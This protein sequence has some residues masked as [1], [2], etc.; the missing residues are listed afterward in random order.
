M[1]ADDDPP[2]EITTAADITNKTKKLYLIQSFSND[3]FYIRND[4]RNGSKKNLNTSNIVT[5]N[6]EFYFLDADIIDGTQYYYIV[7][8]GTGKYIHVASAVSGQALIY[9]NAPAANDTKDLYRFKIVKNNTRN[10]Y[11]IIAKNSDFSLLKKDGNWST[12]VIEL[13][14]ADDDKSCWN[15]V[16]KTNFSKP[17]AP[18]S[19]SSLN[20]AKHNYYIQNNNYTTF[21]LIPGTQ[22]VTTNTQTDDNKVNMMWYFVKAPA[23]ENDPYMDYYYI[24]HAQTGK[25]LRYTKNNTENSDQAVELSNYISSEDDRFK[26]IIVRGSVLDETSTTYC[27]APYL[28]RVQRTENTIS[29]CKKNNGDGGGSAFSVAGVFKE[30]NGNNFTHWNFISATLATPTISVDVTA[31]TFSISATDFPTGCEIRYTT[32][33]GTQDAPTATT[34]SVYTTPVTIDGFTNVKAAIVGYGMVLSEIADV[35]VKCATPTLDYDP[36]THTV[37]LACA[38][39]GSIIH[40]K[41]GDGD[42]TEYNG[43]FNNVVN[44]N[45]I[46]AYA[47][48]A[49][50]LDS[51]PMVPYTVLD[52]CATPSIVVNYNDGTATVTIINNED[53][54]TVHYT[55][56]GSVPNGDS[57]S[58]PLTFDVTSNMITSGMTVR[59]IAVKEHY[60]NSNMAEETVSQVAMPVI[61]IENNTIKITCATD[62]AAIYYTVGGGAATAYTDA[63]GFE[64]SGKAITAYATKTGMVT[65]ATAEADASTTKLQLTAPVITYNPATN[66]VVITSISGATIKYSTGQTETAAGEPTT[67]YNNGDTGFDLPNYHHVIK[68][69]AEMSTAESSEVAILTIVIQ[70][71]T[72][73]SNPRPYLIQSV[74]CTDFYMIPGDKANNIF[75]LNTS[76]LGSA[77]MEWCF[78][79]AGNE[80]GVDYYFIKNNNF[81]SNPYLRYAD[82]R[83]SMQTTAT[84]NAA[85]E[86]GKKAYWFSIVYANT[87]SNPG[88]YIHPYNNATVGN[89]LCK[90]KGNNVTNVVNLADATNTANSN[91]R[92]NFIPSTSYSVPL[93]FTAWGEG[94]DYKYYKIKKEATS[95]VSTHYLLPRT[96]TV[97]YA[98]AS[99]A[100]NVSGSENSISWYFDKDDASSDKWVSYYYVVNAATGE[101]LYFNGDKTKA[102]NENAFEVK[103]ELVESEKDRYLFAF[104]KSTTANFCYILPKALQQ[105]WKKNDYHLIY[106]D[107]SANN[108]EAPLTTAENR[109]SDQ[110]KWTF[111]EVAVADICPP[112]VSLDAAGNVNLIPRTR[113]AVIKY[114]VDGES[115][116]T[117]NGSTDPITTLPSEGG[118]V[119]ITTKTSLVGDP[120]EESINVVYKPTIVLDSDQSIVYNGQTHAPELSSVLLGSTELKDHCVVSSDNINAGEATAVITQIEGDPDYVIYGTAPFTI[121]QSP[122]TIYAD[123]KMIEY[124]EE[125]PELTFSTFG[126]AST[127][128]VEVNL[129]CAPGTE[130]GNYPITFDGTYTITRQ[131][132]GTNAIPNYKDITL[133][134]SSLIITGKSLG[135]GIYFAD[136][137]TAVVTSSGESYDVSVMRNTTS[138]GSDNYEATSPVTEGY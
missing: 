95:T 21:Y 107:N 66:K 74:E 19:L 116:Q 79:Y 115:E 55:T 134:A 51:D 56:D 85:N 126:L 20:G 87:T 5:T 94:G 75:Y 78:Y 38:T 58:T 102:S 44:G 61:A 45:V 113:G 101:Y 108:I 8:N 111:E 28:P 91:A 69:I 57:P 49:N 10:A 13:N 82:D 130:I 118:Q 30:R 135:D 24:I 119:V 37:T 80:G 7:H 33:D 39:T 92:W 2:I 29:L 3:A 15:F 48:M 124:G 100:S 138:I 22:Y 122:L 50:C 76:S 129:S 97:S 16:A 88:Y 89:G 6:S 125:R 123:S 40:Y 114:T 133:V 81:T 65:S 4:T 68:A 86:T 53:G 32:G 105:I 62:E 35:P 67:E 18:F 136:G 25:Y 17:A 96:E 128:V 1:W 131:V 52:V 109:T 117:F 77:S 83:I 14:S 46:Y 43:S 60:N 127:D 59:A 73:D 121:A 63:L 137:I 64:A 98:I 120:A 36:D 84:F 104:T 31:G 34:G 112:K 72:D 54:A 93:P 110:G 41:I 42:Y 103:E 106:W 27:V 90:E 71:T 70:P 12:T 99:V 132:D 9:D 23:S 26:Y 11:N 47:T